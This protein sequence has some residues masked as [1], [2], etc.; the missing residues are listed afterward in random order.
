MARRPGPRR[1]RG[2]GGSLDEALPL[3][4]LEARPFHH[5]GEGNRRRILA[6]VLQDPGIHVT[7]IAERTALSW[8]TAVYHVGLLRRAGQVTVQKVGRERSIFPKGIPTRQQGWLVAMRDQ[9]ARQVLRLL[10]DD[11]TLKAPAIGRRLACSPKVVRSRL[12][13]L[14]R[15]G[16]LDRRGRWRP[17]YD[18]KGADARRIAAL[19]SGM[20]A[21]S[22]RPLVASWDWDPGSGLVT[23]SA[24]AWQ[25]WE[26]PPRPACPVEE[27]LQS[28]DPADRPGF[29]A[30]MATAAA[31][32]HPFDH[33]VRVRTPKGVR[34]VRHRGQ[35]AAHATDGAATRIVGTMEDVTRMVARGLPPLRH[36][37]SRAAQRPD[38]PPRH[39]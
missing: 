22:A 15:A 38:A 23:R 13:T 9:Q 35:L 2:C 39:P 18:V 3:A 32:G 34:Y 19:L 10:M 17:T 28:V 26:L 25:I 29:Q 16:L 5:D 21:G 6:V 36:P 30:V 7:E 1:V 8:H 4:Q 33:T 27:F 31:D 14:R 11:P 24:A 37:R 20:D 12:R